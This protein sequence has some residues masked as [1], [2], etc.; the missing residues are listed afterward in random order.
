M[1]VIT[2]SFKGYG[3]LVRKMATKARMSLEG[4]KRGEIEPLSSAIRMRLR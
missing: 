4:P 2:V 3:D 1:S